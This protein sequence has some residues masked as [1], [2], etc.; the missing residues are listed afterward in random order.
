MN[1]NLNKLYN[2]RMD[3]QTVFTENGDIKNTPAGYE[4]GKNV[5][6]DVTKYRA[7]VTVQEN[8]T[9]SVRADRPARPSDYFTTFN[10]T[11]GVVRER[12]SQPLTHGGLYEVR[13]RFKKYEDFCDNYKSLQREFEDI[14]SYLYSRAQNSN[15]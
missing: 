6:P 15:I 1:K 2:E 3:T 12:I 4:L 14:L 13:F 9:F 8:G 7:T 5:A 11:H 10:T